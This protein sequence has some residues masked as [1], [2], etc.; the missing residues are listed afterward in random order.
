M[1]LLTDRDPPNLPGT[2]FYDLSQ[3]FLRLLNKGVSNV[4][5]EILGLQSIKPVQPVKNIH[6]HFQ[7][8]LLADLHLFTKPCHSTRR[9]W[10]TLELEVLPLEANGVIEEELRSIVENVWESIS[11]EVPMEGAQDIGEHEGDVPS[12]GLGE[13][14]GQSRKCIISTDG[15]A[16]HSTIGEDENCS[17]RVN[18]VL[19]LCRSSLLVEIIVLYIASIDQ[20]WG[21]EDANLRKRLLTPY[22]PQSKASAL[23]VM[24]FLLVN[25]YKRA[26]LV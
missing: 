20:S 23:T 2:P 16:R 7:S 1:S 11:G 25:S 14:G 9:I 26:E 13:D 4:D 10:A 21:I 5:H 17:D 12:Q 24:P 3:E 15:D 18:V 19:D 6:E 22:S 8:G